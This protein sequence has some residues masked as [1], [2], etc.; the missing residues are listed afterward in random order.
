MDNYRDVRAFTVIELLI[1]FAIVG[2][3]AAILIPAIVGDIER[4][5]QPSKITCGGVEY[6]GY[7]TQR[8]GEYAIGYSEASSVTRT[9]KFTTTDGKKIEAS[10][11]VVEETGE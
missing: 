5:S 1:V 6:T 7:V 3:I 9:W 4:R 2:I 11:C 10:E 8:P